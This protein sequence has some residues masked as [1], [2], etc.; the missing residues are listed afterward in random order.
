MLCYAVLCRSKCQLLSC[1]TLSVFAKN[2]TGFEESFNSNRVGARNRCTF[3]AVRLY[4]DS[5]F[6]LHKSREGI[7]VATAT[8]VAAAAAA[9]NQTPSHSNS[10]Q[11]KSEKVSTQSCAIAWIASLNN[12][13][14]KILLKSSIAQKKYF[15]SFVF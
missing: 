9:A 10:S 6:Y 2:Q 4:Y 5:G 3:I 13:M 15:Y 11:E 1:E 14:T 8:A 12:Y 7:A